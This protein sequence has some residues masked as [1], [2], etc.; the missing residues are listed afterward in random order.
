VN[1]EQA[2]RE[3]GV[4]TLAE[5]GYQVTTAANGE[6]TLDIYRARDS[7]VDLV[8]LDLGM[9]GMG[10]QRCLKAILALNPR[11]K[12]VIASGYSAN[13]QV[14]TI[15]Q[16]GAAGFV[17]KPLP[18]PGPTHD[19]T[20]RAGQVGTR[21]GGRQGKRAGMLPRP[22]AGTA[23]AAHART[24][25][26]RSGRPRTI[27]GRT[28]RTRLGSLRPGTSRCARPARRWKPA[29]SSLSTLG[30]SNGVR[31]VSAVAPVR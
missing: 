10:G 6:K 7:E 18:P 27:S 1:E 31:L 23:G 17:V 12:V 14:K 5:M 11:A 29:T 13:G 15:L 30:M 2:L 24:R 9:P 21:A 20:R 3:L 4:K 25:R 16:A 19:C 8:V 28:R 26:A 22:Q